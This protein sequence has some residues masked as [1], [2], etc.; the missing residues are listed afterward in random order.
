MK[1]FGKSLRLPGPGWASIA[2]DDR[3]IRLVFVVWDGVGR[4]RVERLVE[5]TRGADL[6]ADLRQLKK[7]AALSRRR[8]VA[9][10]A[11]GDFQTF[12]MEAPDVPRHELAE[13]VRWRAKDLLGMPLE[14]AVVDAILLPQTSS[15]ES[16]ARQALV[17]CADRELVERVAKPLRDAGLLLAAID[18]P[19]L[20]QRNLAALCEDENRG[21]AFLTLGKGGGLLTLTWG[22]ELFASRRMEEGS[23]LWLDAEPAGRDAAFDRIT[24]ELQRSL[25]YFDRQF[26]FISISR[27]V[28]AG[29]SELADLAVFLGQTV[30]MPVE[31]FDPASVMDMP[32]DPGFPACDAAGLIG[33][34]L[35][36]AEAAA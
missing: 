5:R 35:R 28:L 22:G 17:V 34:A 33:A 10:L 2:I 6:A 14:R 3:Q 23:S 18:I 19:E 25:D 13:A 24:L 20:A 27:L 29:G 16:R 8:C 9:T 21:L 11:Q 12:L 32:E 31:I 15:L 4:P 1:L 36:M 30:Y 26:S 7:D